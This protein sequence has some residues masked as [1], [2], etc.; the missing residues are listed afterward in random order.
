VNPALSQLRIQTQLLFAKDESVGRFLPK[1]V[2]DPFLYFPAASPRVAARG[3]GCRESAQ[4][5]AHKETDPVR[6]SQGPESIPVDS[7]SHR[8]PDAINVIDLERAPCAGQQQR[9]FRS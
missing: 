2:S 4:M 9:W 3:L 6:A 7:L 8:H 5:L 1:I